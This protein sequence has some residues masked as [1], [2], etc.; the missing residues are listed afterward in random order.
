MEMK[1]ILYLPLYVML[2]AIIFGGVASLVG[3]IRE[4]GWLAFGGLLVFA[5]WFAVA[6]LDVTGLRNRN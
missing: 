4:S 2:A 5:A 3:F 1:H 6:L